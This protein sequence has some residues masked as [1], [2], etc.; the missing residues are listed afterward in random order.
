MKKAVEV[1]DD[2]LKSYSLI[3]FGTPATNPLLARAADSLPA[4]FGEGSV[5]IAGKITSLEGRGLV[6]CAPSP[7]S[8]ERYVVVMSGLLWGRYLSLNPKLDFVPDYIGFEDEP[9]PADPMDRINRAVQAG[10]FDVHWGREPDKAPPPAPEEGSGL[11]PKILVPVLAAT[12]LAAVAKKVL[13]R[14]AA[15]R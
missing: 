5:E 2:D 10:L 6:L 9:D 11:L 14:T 7:F 8:A 4:K 15:R 1:T 12:L 3:L 13:D